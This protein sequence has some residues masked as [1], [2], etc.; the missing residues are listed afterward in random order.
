M[1]KPIV[2]D[3]PVL[4]AR[5]PFTRMFLCAEYWQR[6]YRD[7]QRSFIVPT[8]GKQLGEA[9]RELND[10]L[11]PLIQAWEEKHGLYVRDLEVLHVQR[12]GAPP[13]AL[14]LTITPIMAG[15]L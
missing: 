8:L 1:G 3:D 10:A 7:L 2:L 13:V 5:D 4:D 11:L 9:K 14:S 6:K 12:I 15:Q